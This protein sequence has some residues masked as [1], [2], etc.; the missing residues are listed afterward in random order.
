MEE[1]IK[2]LEEWL[3]EL[4]EIFNKTHINNTKERKALEHLIKSY[5]ELEEENKKN[6]I[7]IICLQEELEDSIPKA[8]VMERIKQLNKGIEEFKEYVA[9]STGEEKQFYKKYLGQFVNTRNE[10]QE[11]LKDLG[12]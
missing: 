5:K 9:D 7:S 12:E 3:K 6:S 1:D 4:N 10:L 8:K 2:I 11:L